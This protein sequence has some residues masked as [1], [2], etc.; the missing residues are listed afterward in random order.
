M[1][2]IGGL[3]K[4]TLIDYPRKVAAIVFTHGCNFRCP[5]CHNPELVTEKLRDDIKI[6][7]DYFFEFLKKRVGKL[8]GVVITGGEPLVHKDIDS[9][10]GK[11]KE[12]GFLVKLDTNGAY[13]DRLEALLDSGNIDYIA[14]DVK[15]PLS[16][17]DLVSPFKNVSK[18]ISKSIYMIKNSGIDYEFRT[19]YIK[20]FHTME[21]VQEIGKLVKGAKRYYI[22]NFRA[23]KTVDPKFESNNSFTQKELKDIES[24]I[25]KYVKNVEIR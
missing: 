17:Y 23:G 13:P 20:S 9:F 5:Y 2:P 24:V 15:H 6:T 25:K 8:D 3:E 4:S 19:T 14:M 18:D 1:I 21:S 16:D 12:L 11:I 22:Q 7:E 10:I